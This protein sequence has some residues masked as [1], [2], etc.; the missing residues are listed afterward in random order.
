MCR[1]A[2]VGLALLGAMGSPGAE[3]PPLAGTTLLTLEGDLAAQMVAGID[4][5]LDRERAA[6]VRE[7]PGQWSRDFTTPDAYARSV[8]TNRQRLRH[9]LGVVD[10]RLPARAQVRGVIGDDF[11]SAARGEVGRGANYRIY[12]VAWDVLRQVEG[13]GLLLEPDAVPAA[14]VIAL[15]D[16]DQTPEALVGLEPG[17][18]PGAQFARRLAENGCRVLVPF[19]I[20]RGDTCS[21]LPGVRQVRQSQREVLWRA[22]FEMG[23]TVAGYEIQKVLAGVD[24]LLQGSKGAPVGVFGYGEGGMLALYAGALDRRISALGVSGYFQPRELLHEEPISRNV[25]SLL[26]QF[27]DAEVAGLIAPRP[28]IVESGRYPETTYP[29]AGQKHDGAAPGKLVPPAVVEVEREVERARAW[30]RDVPGGARLTFVKA[31]PD[32]MGSEAA[33]AAF[34]TALGM[35]GELRPDVGAPALE[36]RGSPM[37]PKG[38]LRHQYTQ[39]LEDTQHLMREAEFTRARFWSKASGSNAP[40]FEAGAGWYKEYLWDE[41]IGRLPKAELP[42][43]PRTRLVYETAAFRGYEVV[44][45]VYADVFA[46]GV[47]LVPKDVNSGAR[48]PVVVCQHGLEGRPRDVADPSV[49][50]PAYHTYACRLAERGFVVFAPQNPY[51]GQNVFR[52]VLRKAQP[53]QRSLYGVIVRQHEVILD[54]LAT[55]D[56]VDPER[57]AFYGLSYGGK[58]AMRIPPLLERYCLSI[59]SADYNEWIWKNVSA[60]HGYCYLYWG[61]Y[62]MPEFNLGNTFNYA[63]LSWL[64]FPR[65]FMVERGH[66]DGVAPDEWV[67]YEYAKTRRHYVKLGLA[68]RTAIEFFDGPHTIHGKGTFDFLHTHLRWPPPAKAP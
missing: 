18:A 56:Y 51:I 57:M 17:V 6:A 13:E 33:L 67:A 53:L 24:W 16:C 45:D 1:V 52:Q 54:W 37:D 10:D 35:S 40:A 3:A 9:I 38:R 68:D 12:S 2:M 23:R 30:V 14:I 43:N 29:P 49:D 20:D 27:G 21:G 47:L 25:W 66:D 11:G 48:R 31:A 64:V 55:L 28:L 5:F 39:I 60:R 15:P 46:F 42:P 44:L 59:C 34:L 63:E 7:R 4:R 58:T 19:L 65:P 41:I 62:D 61:E 32:V 36:G 8:E 26:R 22:A 50:H